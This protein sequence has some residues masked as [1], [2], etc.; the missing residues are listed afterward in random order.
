MSK[1]KILILDFLAIGDILF[2]TPLLETVRKNFESAKI[3]M[4]VRKNVKDIL[5][6]NNDIDELILYDKKG[7]HNTLLGYI[8]YVNKLR[9]I[10]ADIVLTLQDNP[11]LALLTYFSK[12]P[13]RIGFVDN[14]LRKLFYTDPIRPNKEKHRV[15]YY[16]DLARVMKNIKDIKNNGLKLNI[17]DKEKKWAKWILNKHNVNLKKKIIGLHIGGTWETKRW[18]VEKFAK[19]GEKLIEYGFEVIILG[20]PQDVED[21][22][23]I[24]KYMKK[25]VINFAGKTT[26]LQLT[27]LLDYFNLFISGDTGPLHMA[28]ARNTKSLAIFGPSEVWRYRPYGEKH[29]VI[30]MNLKCQP[31]HEKKCP[32]NWE[33]MNNLKV[34]DVFKKALTLL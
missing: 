17:T 28:V 3:I 24:E 10:N 26:L 34:E 23:K 11:R 12:A 22:I 16:L 31:C 19:L 18:P 32:F 9:T 30:K 1:K 21:S 2:T 29:E 4:S 7:K 25:K 5:L 6:Y 20:G 27:G 8:S 13:K 14:Y 33:C 15:E